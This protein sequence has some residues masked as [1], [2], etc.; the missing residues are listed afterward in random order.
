M[1]LVKN[2]RKKIS[3]A[4]RDRVLARYDYKCQACG[5]RGD[6]W[7]NVLQLDHP[8]PLRD[9]GDNDQGL[10][11]LCNQC[12]SRKSYLEA[13]T[14]FSSK[15]SGERVRALGARCVCVFSQA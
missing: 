9:H 2:K 13:L 15:S 12:H 1:A 5:D 10:V 14:P 8:S 6:T 11:P 3:K 4:D 7:D